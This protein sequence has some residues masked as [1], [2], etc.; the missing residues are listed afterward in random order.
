MQAIFQ[1]LTD[2]QSSPWENSVPFFSRSD[3]ETDVVPCQ[4]GQVLIKPQIWAFTS[5]QKKKCVFLD[6]ESLLS[7][8]ISNDRKAQFC[9]YKYTKPLTL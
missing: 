8:S 4:S 7:E 9:D 3:S 6:H 1:E 5:P 2:I